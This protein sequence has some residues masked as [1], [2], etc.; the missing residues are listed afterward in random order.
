[1]RYALGALALTIALIGAGVYFRPAAT[2]PAKPQGAAATEKHGH[3]KGAH[4]GAIIEIGNDS[5]HAEAVFEKNGTIRLYTLGKDEARVQE[6]EVQTLDAHVKAGPHG[7]TARIALEAK[8]QPGDAA[9]KTSQ[10]VGELPADLRGQAVTITVPSIRID[11]ERYRFSFA[12]AANAHESMPARIKDDKERALYL[13]PGGKYTEADIQANGSTTASAKYA[14][15]TPPHDE[16]KPGDKICPVT[17]TVKADPACTWIIGGDKYTFCCP[18]CVDNFVKK[19]K[20]KPEE[21]LKPE[22]YVKQ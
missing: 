5:Y 14:D 1:M 20:Q 16:P 12:S 18:P 13:T 2:T 7:G 9:G 17:K 19:A 15:L 6:V 21:I 11:G 10:F 3:K 22:A 4:Q 8:P